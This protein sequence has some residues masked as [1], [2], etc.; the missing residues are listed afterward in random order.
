MKT[1]NEI[2]FCIGLQSSSDEFSILGSFTHSWFLFSASSQ[3]FKYTHIS[4]IQVAI[5]L[6]HS[7]N[8]LL[9]ALKAYSDVIVDSEGVSLSWIMLESKDMFMWFALVKNIKKFISLFV[10]CDGKT[11]IKN[12]SGVY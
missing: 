5:E 1:E 11:T 3:S 8:T 9:P 7:V 4:N 12:S 10:V 6:L 2:I